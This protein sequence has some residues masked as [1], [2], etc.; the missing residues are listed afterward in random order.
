VAVTEH[1]LPGIAERDD[2]GSAGTARIVSY[3]PDRVR[4]DAR[5]SR[6]GLVVLGDN[7]FPGWKAEVDGR[8][9][10]VERVDYVLRAAAVDRGRHTVEFSY[11]PASWRIGW[12][13]S[14]LTLMALAAALL[15]HRRAAGRA[16]APAERGRSRKPAQAR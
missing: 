14:L 11:R 12:I 13:V 3:E 7:W 16:A 2:G 1:R 5:L 15:L 4:I 9:V 8:P 10:D 6:P